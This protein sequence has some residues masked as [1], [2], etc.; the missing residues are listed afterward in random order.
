MGGGGV[1][2]LEH[3]V[4]TAIGLRGQKEEVTP[5]TS[6]IRA[7]RPL[8]KRVYRVRQ[9]SMV[10]TPNTLYCDVGHTHPAHARLVLFEIRDENPRVE[11]Y[12]KPQAST[13]TV[14]V[15]KTAISKE[16]RST[17]TSTTCTFTAQ[18]QQNHHQPTSRQGCTRER[19]FMPASSMDKYAR[20]AEH[21]FS[22]DT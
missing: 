9:R 13:P 1:H 21:A 19:N 6:Q 18:Q 7:T 11:K 20:R 4:Q 5:L 2:A 12:D 14:C 10:T 17:R 8:K 16:I 3:G 15:P 22:A